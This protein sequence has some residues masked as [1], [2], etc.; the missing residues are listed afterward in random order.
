M[1]TTICNRRCLLSLLNEHTF[2]SIADNGA[3][4]C[5]IGDGWHIESYTSRKANLVGFDAKASRETG[6]PIVS[7]V[8]VVETQ[9]NKYLLRVHEAVCNQGSPTT[10]LSE[11]QLREHDCIVDSISTKHPTSVPGRKGGQCF[12]PRPHVYIPFII[13]G[14]GLMTFR[15]R[16]P[17]ERELTSLTPID[18]TADSPWDPNS[19]YSDP[20]L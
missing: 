16:L 10:L 6:M 19:H 4:T 18:I 7:A 11:F 15:H 3:D 17:T 1:N 2:L 9:G 14:G 12:L 8:T 13:N 5:V 20:C